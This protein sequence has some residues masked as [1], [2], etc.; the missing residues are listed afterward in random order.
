MAV[1]IGK[2]G[3]TLIELMIVV[4]VLAVLAAIAYPSYQSYIKKTKRVEV[5]THLMQIAQNLENYK[6]ANHNYAGATL[7]S[8]GG[9]Q[10]P[11]QGT[12]NYQITL[13]NSAGVALTTE[14]AENQSWLLI[15]RPLSTSGQ[16]NT[17][18]LS[19]NSAQVKCWYKDKDD[20]KVIAGVDQNNNP[21]PPDTCTN[22]WTDR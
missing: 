11:T 5:Q 2:N 1:K 16:K 7:A 17:G 12:A 19:L 18:A 14:N 20:A 8:W 10:F 6:L 22:K 3:F 13:T 21:T 15:A 4:A 9:T